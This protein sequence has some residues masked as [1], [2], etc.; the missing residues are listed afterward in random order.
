VDLV[1]S[2]NA[3]AITAIQ[4]GLATSTELSALETHG[5]STWATANTDLLAKEANIQNHVGSVLET[6]GYTDT[7]SAFLDKLNFVGNI[8]IEDNIETHVGYVVANSVVSGVLTP[9][10]TDAASREASK[11]DVSALALENNI[12]GHVESGIANVGYTDTRASYLDKLNV[13]GDLVDTDSMN[14]IVTYAIENSIV[15]GVLTPVTTDT[16]SRNASKADISA[17]ALEAN[18]EGHVNYA[19]ENAVVSGVL[20]PVVTDSASREAS[21]ADISDLALEANIQNHVASGIVGVGYT[22]TRAGYIDKLNVAGTLATDTTIQPVVVYAVENAIV[23]GVLTPV[24]TD[25]ASR[26]ASKAD[27]TALAIEANIYNHVVSGVVDTGY[28]AER[29]VFL[30]KLNVAGDLAN[31]DNA[32]LFSAS[33]VS[34]SGIWSYG[35]R[36]LT[37]GEAPSI[38][39]IDA[40]LTIQHGAGTWQTGGVVGSNVVTVTTYNNNGLVVGAVVEVYASG[41]NT[42]LDLSTTDSA[43]GQAQFSLDNGAYDFRTY[44][45]GH[46][47]WTNPDTR[48]VSGTTAIDLTGAALSIPAPTGGD[49]VRLYGYVYDLGSSVVSDV[50]LIV[51]PS[52]SWSATNDVLIENRAMT[53]LSN[54]TGFVFIDVPINASVRIT[55]PK[56]QVDVYYQTPA[57]GVS[58]N[59]ADLV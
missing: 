35:D 21:K 58:V 3:T 16:E 50:E 28:T 33:G 29:S 41:S 40:Y 37:A 4:S 20:T 56:A 45:H 10:V 6:L 19:V 34:V 9:V 42:L 25:S 54:T 5:D 39:E 15:S 48:T 11:A 23:S 59:I 14:A 2:P 51:R 8:A 22:D 24:T 27:V 30:D 52:G 36:T 17:L 1:D 55:I 38:E 32:E 43:T 44:K 31:T 53:A 47:Y 13:S 46:T 26:E 49:L 7:R 57:S 12:Q 18:I